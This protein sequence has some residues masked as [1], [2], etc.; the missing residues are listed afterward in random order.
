MALK[1][2]KRQPNDQLDLFGRDGKKHDHVDS[3]RIDGRG[4]LAGAPATDGGG[5]GADGHAPANV[6]GGRGE[7]QGR[8]DRTDAAV[9]QT[10]RKSVV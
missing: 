3:I 4:T 2:S 9:H 6:A 1:R 8:D 10:D 7:D 5:N